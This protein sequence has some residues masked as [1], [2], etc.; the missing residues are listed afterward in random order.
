[1]VQMTLITG[2]Q[3][4]RLWNDADRARILAAISKPGAVVAE[5]ARR[6]DVCTG[7]IYQWRRTARREQSGVA[8]GF[9][10]VIIE[11]APP[12]SSVT[13]PTPHSGAGVVDV[14]LN[15]ARVRFAADA[16]AA[17]IAATLKALRP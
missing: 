3:R 1:M 2:A 7:L 14:E 16:P 9:S 8:D 4:R 13:T 12:A 17:V 10:P 11:A 5:V 6:E 15:G